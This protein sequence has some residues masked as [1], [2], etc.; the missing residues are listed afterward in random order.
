MEV[1]TRANGAECPKCNSEITPGSGAGPE[2]V[3]M[4]CGWKGHVYLF[5]PVGAVVRNAREAI[6]E[7]ATCANH[8]TKRAETVC[9]G[10]GNYIC[11]LCAVE[12]DD[13]TYSVQ[14][15]DG[16]GKNE[17]TRLFGRYLE[18][19]DYSM[20]FYLALALIIWP[21]A[22][23]LVPMGLFQF[24]KMIKLRGKNELFAKVVNKYRVALYGFV[25]ALLVMGFLGI[26]GGIAYRLIVG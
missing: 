1:T 20:G 26:L 3:C 22:V 16:K 7:D 10:T 17:L 12:I 25:A 9:E 24:Y 15:L 21:A 11:A 23:I 19:P 2:T 8:P 14:Y 13:K 5:N 6:P 4:S 18:R